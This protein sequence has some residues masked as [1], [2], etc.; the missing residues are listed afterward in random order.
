MFFRKALVV[1]I[2]LCFPLFSAC[3]KTKKTENTSQANAFQLYND[4]LVFSVSFLPPGGSEGLCFFRKKIDA[5]QKE[6][7]FDLSENVEFIHKF[8]VSRKELAN[9]LSKQTRRTFF[10]SIG[11]FAQK[12]V[13]VTAAPF[14]GGLSLMAFGFAID[15]AEKD[16]ESVKQGTGPILVKIQAGQDALEQGI[17]PIGYDE[18]QALENVLDA[19]D[20]N[21][22]LSC[23]DVLQQSSAPTP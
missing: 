14:T 11:L 23:T 18:Y 10:T 12:A 16:N 2:L 22:T 7:S 9:Q 3:E 17:E 13:A 20:K 15:G 19:T 21:G 1:S 8:A 6:V 4:T 5:G